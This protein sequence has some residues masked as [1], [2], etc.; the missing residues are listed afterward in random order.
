MASEDD[1][2]NNLDDVS[3][4]G[5]GLV[6]G[7]E[8]VY[9]TEE[10]R[11]VCGDTENKTLEK[12]EIDLNR[13]AEF[14]MSNEP[15]VATEMNSEIA[16]ENGTESGVYCDL[17]GESQ[18][19]LKSSSV[20]EPNGSLH[21]FRETSVKNSVENDTATALK[22]ISADN[23]APET[24]NEAF[25]RVEKCFK[26]DVSISAKTDSRNNS[27]VGFVGS[28]AKGMSNGQV[29]KLPDDIGSSMVV[30]T[31]LP[32]SR[33]SEGKHSQSPDK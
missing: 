29:A 17:N 20:V 11:V 13:P 9:V 27:R 2:V 8:D 10:E 28:V 22:N 4:T 19:A 24:R 5:N 1:R 23:V 31:R 7:F 16:N 25:A 6:D 3:G 18:Y 14:T 12:L 30:G 32:S 26:S 15:E 33:R 21:C